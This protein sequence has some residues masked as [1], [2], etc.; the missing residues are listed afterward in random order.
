MNSPPIV[1]VIHLQPITVRC[2]TW[3]VV[4]TSIRFAQERHTV[5][6][7]RALQTLKLSLLI[8]LSILQI[9]PLSSAI[10]MIIILNRG[11]IQLASATLRTRYLYIA[12]QSLYWTPLLTE[13]VVS[14]QPPPYPTSFDP[15]GYPAVPTKTASPLLF[16]TPDWPGAGLRPTF[17]PSMTKLVAPSLWLHMN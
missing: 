5:L 3:C 13:G 10:I 16:W 6:G 7:P 15:L 17:K 4:L 9:C 11:L 14:K 2:R 8:V 1:I 12:S